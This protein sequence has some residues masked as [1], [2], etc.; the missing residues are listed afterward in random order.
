MNYKIERPKK[1]L[2]N[3]IRFKDIY[4]GRIFAI[5]DIYS[6]DDVCLFIKIAPMKSGEIEYNAIC[7]DDGEPCKV[8]S[9]RAI[10]LYSE[11]IKFDVT[12]FISRGAK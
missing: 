9:E 3:L 7:L 2:S 1:D 6:S 5:G 12:K 8:E 10:S 11:A 4:C